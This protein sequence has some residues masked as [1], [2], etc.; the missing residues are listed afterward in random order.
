MERLE[1]KVAIVERLKELQ[2]GEIAEG[3]SKSVRG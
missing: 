1:G 2:L 3:L